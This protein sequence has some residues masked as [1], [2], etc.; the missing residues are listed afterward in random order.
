LITCSCCR[1]SSADNITLQQHD[2]DINDANAAPAATTC[3]GDRL[4]QHQ[5]EKFLPPYFSDPG[6][7]TIVGA[8]ATRSLVMGLAYD[9]VYTGDV[10]GASL[11][12]PESVTH[13]LDMQ[14]RVIQLVVGTQRTRRDGTKAITVTMPPGD[15]WGGLVAPPGPYMLFL[16]NGQ[17]PSRTAQWVR[18]RA[19]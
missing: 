13:Q 10:T 7:P 19:P 14:G 9:F 4:Y 2:A 12:A 17:L 11:V 16:L 6:R 18:L 8:D 3:G 1:L 5:A 15:A